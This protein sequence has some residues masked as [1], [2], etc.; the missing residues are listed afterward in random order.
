MNRKE[1]HKLRKLIEKAAVSLGDEDALEAVLLFPTW[2]PETDYIKGQRVR[3]CGKLYRLIPETHHAQAD[4]TPDLTP[5][6][7]ARI[8]DPGEEWPEWK[9]PLPEEAYQAGARV[10]HNG[11]HW[12]NTY[13]DG[14]IWEPG[15]YGWDEYISGNTVL[16]VF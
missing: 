16:T 10:S 1:A 12:L 13:G 11:K 3:F 7:W 8:D 5:A 14:N 4:W 9:Q 6:I 2:A 15:V